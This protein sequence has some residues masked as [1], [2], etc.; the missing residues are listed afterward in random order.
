MRPEESFLQKAH[1]PFSRK[2]T[3][4]FTHWG[5][6]AE[7]DR[8]QFDVHSAVSLFK[9]RGAVQPPNQATACV[10]RRFLFIRQ[11]EILDFTNAS[12][13]GSAVQFVFINTCIGVLELGVERKFF[14][15]CFI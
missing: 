9:S 5:I 11:T 8:F 15:Y 10:R 1:L 4:H 13:V 3:A 7:G 2:Y 14:Y 6:P 12:T